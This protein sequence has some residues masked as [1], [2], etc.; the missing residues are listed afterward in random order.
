MVTEIRGLLGVLGHFMM[1][2]VECD[3]PVKFQA[4]RSTNKNFIGNFVD[5]GHFYQNFTF[6][7]SVEKRVDRF[8]PNFAEI[9]ASMIVIEC[10][11][12]FENRTCN[13]GKVR[14]LVSYH[15]WA[16]KVKLHFCGSGT[17]I[18]QKVAVFFAEI[19]SRPSL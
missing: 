13:Y 14:I 8:L 3:Q 17:E 9:N 12:N 7:L 15:Y 2:H 18:T 4:D 5:F 19:L 16:Q 10:K 1:R 6:F 11:K